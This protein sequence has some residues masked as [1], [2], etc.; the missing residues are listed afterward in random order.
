MYLFSHDQCSTSSE[1]STDKML[2]LMRL[3]STLLN[4]VLDLNFVVKK[5]Y[6]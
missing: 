6:D 4:K 3:N 1:G 2:I 5:K